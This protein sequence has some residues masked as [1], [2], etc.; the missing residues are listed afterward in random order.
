ML[1]YES[2]WKQLPPAIT[3]DMN[4]RPMHS[5]R[6]LLLPYLEEQRVYD[7]Y[8]FDEPWDGPNNSKL[9]SQMPRIY[10][11]PYL[12]ELPKND[13]TSG[14]RVLVGE[15]T[16]FP[17][18]GSRARN[19]IRDGWASTLLIVESNQLVP[20]MAPSEPTVDEYM[21]ELRGWM[22]GRTPHRHSDL[23]TNFD[24]GGS[25]ALADGSVRHCDPPTDER[26]F[27]KLAFIDNGVLTES[28][29]D[30]F[31]FQGGDSR[32]RWE[33][34]LAIAAFLIVAVLPAFWLFRPKRLVA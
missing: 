17:P 9:L 4:G 16:C 34:Y 29:F 13:F 26:W 32:I 10:R 1:N 7:L 31:F 14:Y 8:S 2:V 22:P 23:L 24:I 6:V 15:R 18:N 25:C 28:E 27:E 30:S 20:W 5:W 21:V 12:N 3:Y 19:E 33:G 11:C